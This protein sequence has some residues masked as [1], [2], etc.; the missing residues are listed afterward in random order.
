MT[1]RGRPG[2]LVDRRLSRRELLIVAGIADTGLDLGLAGCRPRQTSVVALGTPT[3][4]IPHALRHRSREPRASSLSP[5]QTA[6]ASS[7]SR[8]GPR[9]GLR[10][11]DT[12]APASGR[13]FAPDRASTSAS[14]SETIRTADSPDIPGRF[15]RTGVVTQ[16]VH[17]ELEDIGSGRSHARTHVIVADLH[18]RVVDATRG[19]LA[20][21]VSPD[22]R[23]L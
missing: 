16:R 11:W 12:T 7:S 20:I 5:Q 22:Y 4:P 18:V 23:T 17:G 8:A 15:T 21:D 13:R 14:P 3:L 1:E 6:R 19:E 10:R 2:R 9:G